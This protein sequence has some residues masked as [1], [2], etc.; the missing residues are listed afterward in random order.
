M[1]KGNKEGDTPRQRAPV[2]TRWLTTVF[3]RATVAATTRS[4]NTGARFQHTSLGWKTSLPIYNG[5]LAMHGFVFKLFDFVLDLGIIALMWH[6][7]IAVGLGNFLCVEAVLTL[8]SGNSETVVSV[9]CCVA[10]FL[11]FVMRLSL[12]CSGKR[13]GVLLIAFADGHFGQS[14]R[15][16]GLVAQPQPRFP[17][18]AGI[19]RR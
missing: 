14:C 4:R 18:D 2:L 5:I 9:S 8:C 10:M 3:S 1:M 12:L 17:W 7:C 13:D 6:N 11:S 19:T 16:G 15:L